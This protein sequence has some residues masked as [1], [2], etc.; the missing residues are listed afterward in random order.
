MTNIGVERLKFPEILEISNSLKAGLSRDEV[1]SLCMD[2]GNCNPT[3]NFGKT[4]TSQELN[5]RMDMH[6]E[7]PTKTEPEGPLNH[8]VVDDLD[9]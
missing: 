5:E 9:N 2:I 1:L 8:V 4:Q 6:D 3:A 7:S